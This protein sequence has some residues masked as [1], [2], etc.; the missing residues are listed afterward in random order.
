MYSWRLIEANDS[1]ALFEVLKPCKGVE[2]ARELSGSKATATRVLQA[3]SL[4]YY[5]RGSANEEPTPVLP[6]D[7]LS[8]GTTL[9]LIFEAGTNAT[10]FF[11]QCAE[12][13]YEDPF[14]LAANKPAGLLVHSSGDGGPRPTLTDLVRAHLHAIGSS[15][16]NRAQAVQRLDVETTGV[17]LFSK[18]RELQ[19]RFD[20]LVAGHDI[21]KY[22]LAVIP[23]RLERSTIRIDEPI[24]H[25]RHDAKRMR[26]S[27][28]GKRSVT[29]VSQLDY[30]EG[31]SLVRCQLLTGRRHQIRVHLAYLGYPIV[32]DTLYGGPRSAGGLMLHAASESFEHPITGE[33]VHI[34]APWPTRF[35]AFFTP[36]Q[37]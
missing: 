1:R 37:A 36:L 24:G 12:V 11:P 19:P 13:L 4:Q 14:M 23:G 3:E 8:V 30:S 29:I 16:A 2:F 10:E 32:G 9:Q 33:P 18:T 6:N 5:E 27:P 26:V 15:A 34:E 7:R 21:K 25:D 17:V 22:Y 31:F 35:S 28:S 20:A